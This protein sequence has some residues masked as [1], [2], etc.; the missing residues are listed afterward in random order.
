MSQQKTPQAPEPTL[1]DIMAKL[2]ELEKKMESR[3][4]KLESD[5]NA[6]NERVTNVLRQHRLQSAGLPGLLDATTPAGRAGPSNENLRSFPSTPVVIGMR[7]HQSMP[8]TPA[9]EWPSPPRFNLNGNQPSRVVQNAPE[10]VPRVPN[11][12][13]S[14]RP[15][16]EVDKENH[17]ANPE[18]FL[19]SFERVLKCHGIDIERWGSLWLP[20]RMLDDD[21]LSLEDRAENQTIPDNWRQL[22]ELFL[23]V[24]TPIQNEGARFAELQKMRFNPRSDNITS[25]TH[26]FDHLRKRAGQNDD[27]QELLLNIF[28][29]SLPKELRRLILMNADVRR[30]DPPNI[31]LLYTIAQTEYKIFCRIQGMEDTTR[32]KKEPQRQVSFGSTRVNHYNPNDRIDN[33]SSRTNTSYFGRSNIS[34]FNTDLPR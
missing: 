24:F 2:I 27:K 8:N 18:A 23:E 16:N 5:H 6:L 30:E 7:T 4:E 15:L 31:R 12:L 29:D 17:Y 25:Y 3:F 33:N 34:P 1:A 28:Y 20:A 21:V 26:E 11:D 9:R 32:P 19:C 22:K 14:F 10:L 13:P